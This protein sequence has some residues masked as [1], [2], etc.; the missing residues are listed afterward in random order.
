MMS[1]LSQSLTAINEI[2]L[3]PP[4]L[5]F[6]LEAIANL[7]F[8]SPGRIYSPKKGFWMSSFWNCDKSERRLL[9]FF[10]NRLA[11]LSKSGTVLIVQFI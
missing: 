8:L 10:A 3:A 11:S 7:F 5:P 1:P 4:D 2:I 6:P 9:Y